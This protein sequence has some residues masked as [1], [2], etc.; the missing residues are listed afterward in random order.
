MNTVLIVIGVMVGIVILLKLWNKFT[1][2]Y[3]HSILGN[4][5][6]IKCGTVLGEESLRAA[7]VKLNEEKEQLKKGTKIGAV[8][9][10]NMELVCSNCGALS[11]ERDLYRMNRKNKKNK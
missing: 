5:E 7:I 10:H 6:C 9:L 4:S 11:L 2:Q 1:L 8:R 3:N